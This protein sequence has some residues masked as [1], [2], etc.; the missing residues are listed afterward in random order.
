MIVAGRVK[1][2]TVSAGL[3]I[4]SGCILAADPGI[5]FSSEKDGFLAVQGTGTILV[6]G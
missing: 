2:I 6:T 1:K 3:R 4:S 5:S